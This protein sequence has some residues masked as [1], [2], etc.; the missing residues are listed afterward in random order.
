[1]GITEVKSPTNSNYPTN[2]IGSVN[3]RGESPGMT[4]SP[5]NTHYLTNKVGS[6]VKRGESPG[7]R[8]HPDARRDSVPDPSPHG[9]TA[10]RHS[11]N[12][13]PEPSNARVTGPSED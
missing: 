5:V 11:Q 1:M 7:S 4:L 2:K 10:S 3:T 6:A 12:K 9:G 13:E 8:S